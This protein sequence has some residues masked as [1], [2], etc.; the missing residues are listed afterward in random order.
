MHI[1]AFVRQSI[2]LNSATHPIQH[3]S[4]PSPI[5]TT[6]A[7][8]KQATSTVETKKSPS[9][10]SPSGLVN[11]VRNNKIVVLG[12]TFLIVN[13][14]LS[15]QPDHLKRPEILARNRLEARVTNRIQ[16]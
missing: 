16:K 9:K 15:F 3:P 2:N 14:V 5:A 1:F 10:Y 12:L 6:T 4:K 7:T 13:I 11:F 8:L